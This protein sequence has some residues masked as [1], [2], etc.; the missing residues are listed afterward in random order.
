MT[1]APEYEIPLLAPLP[2]G[3]GT[4]GKL[5]AQIALIA[6]R[7]A[8]KAIE[9]RPNCDILLEVYAAGFAHG[10]T[11]T[12]NTILNTEPA[13]KSDDNPVWTS[14]TPERP[15][16]LEVA[17]A[18]AFEM[19]YV[20]PEHQT[21]ETAWPTHTNL[22]R[23]SAL[24]AA[25]LMRQQ[26]STMTRK[27]NEEN[28]D[29]LAEND[30]LTRDKAALERLNGELTQR[31]VKLQREID[32]MNKRI[33]GYRKSAQEDDDRFNFLKAEIHNSPSGISFDLTASGYRFMRRWQIGSPQATVREAIDEAMK[34]KS[35]SV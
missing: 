8:K 24:K 34:T 5:R 27:H 31:A 7:V 20:N 33:E 14:E 4:F 25:A 18:L 10:Q 11:L 13:E 6:K 28:Q 30:N 9:D 29:L 3:K 26:F 16:D 1:D 19:Y 2:S 21:P 23:S 22:E 17:Q 32:A 12:M 15:E 35:L